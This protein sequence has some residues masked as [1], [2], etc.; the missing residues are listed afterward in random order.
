M[1]VRITEPQM[2]VIKKGKPFDADSIHGVRMTHWDLEDKAG[3]VL[4]KRYGQAA[5]KKMVIL[6]Y[7]KPADFEFLFG[8][9]SS[10]AIDY[11]KYEATCGMLSL[12]EAGYASKNNAEKAASLN[13][14]IEELEQRGVPREWIDEVIDWRLSAA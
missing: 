4:T 7:E 9:A 11:L 2:D 8:R 13:A 14:F 3:D 6:E 1:L 10:R 5:V 12:E